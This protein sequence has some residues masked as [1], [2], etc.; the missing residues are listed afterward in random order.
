MELADVT[1]VTRY[2]E[3]LRDLLSESSFVERKSFVKSFIKEVKITGNQA[4]LAYTIP[5]PSQEPTSKC[6][7][8]LLYLWWAIL[9][10]NQ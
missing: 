7:F 9:D 6:Q 4:V 5:M 2:A 8:C 3:D 10:L 1:T